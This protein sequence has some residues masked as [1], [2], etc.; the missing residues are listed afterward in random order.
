MAN[1]KNLKSIADRTESERREIARKG[2]KASGKKRR[3]RKEFKEALKTA[4]EIVYKD[5]KTIQ[6]IGIEALL[7]KF[8]QG[9]LKAFELVR[10]TIGEAPTDK[11]EVKMADTDWFIDFGDIP[12]HN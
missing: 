1:T 12:E 2:G 10:N 3:E 9:D 6:D 5:N 7:E 4:L 8:M 11:K